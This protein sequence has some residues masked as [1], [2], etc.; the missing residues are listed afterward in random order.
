MFVYSANQSFEIAFP[1][2]DVYC[3]KG[4]FSPSLEI[5]QSVVISYRCKEKEEERQRG[6]QK[7]F[8]SFSPSS[9]IPE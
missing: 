8:F 2:L 4:A 9:T 1:S 3:A 6:Q 7:S 5:I